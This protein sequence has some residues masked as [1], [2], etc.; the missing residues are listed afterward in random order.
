V[1]LLEIGLSITGT[2]GNS[3][4]LPPDFLLMLVALMKVMRLSLGRAA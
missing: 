4:T 2:A 3:T 1:L